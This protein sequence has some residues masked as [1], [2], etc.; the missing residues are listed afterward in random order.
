M[1]N[2]KKNNLEVIENCTKKSCDARYKSKDF[3]TQ[4]N[5]GNHLKILCCFDSFRPPFGRSLGTG[6]GGKSL[7]SLL[8]NLKQDMEIYVL[9]FNNSISA[10][11]IFKNG[12]HLRNVNYFVVP[13][14][15]QITEWFRDI[16][17]QR[18]FREMISDIKPDLIISQRYA[19]PSA[20][21]GGHKNGIPTIAFV[22]SYKY[23]YPYKEIIPDKEKEVIAVEGGEIKKY[24]R[25][26]RDICE[27]P[28]AKN[29][30]KRNREA[31]KK[32]NVVVVNSKFMAKIAEESYK[33]M[34]EV[35]YP[36]V[37]FSEFKADERNPKYITF[38]RPAFEKGIEIFLR[39]AQKLTDK[40]FLCVGEAS[41]AYEGKLRR[42]NNIN[43]TGWVGDMKSIYAETKI[44]IV[45]SLCQEAFGRV[46]VES[47]INKIPCIVSNR[48]GLPEVV[49]D[50]ALIVEN[51][52]DVQDWCNKI[53]YLCENLDVYT[54]LSERCF[55]RAKLFDPEKQYQ[56]FRQLIKQLTH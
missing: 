38:I 35:I 26:L 18:I 44:L 51:P 19:N 24:L 7:Y 31:I 48:G 16:K 33:I 41:K 8:S 47:M 12:L 32:T 2:S 9:C 40:K 46:V 17:Q 39:I 23:L 1:T 37:D 42:L 14:F 25:Y 36:F 49:G 20:V 28:I 30:V 52:Y 11:K 45:P 4:I 54:D 27:Y 3:K 55:K 6:G 13:K 34:P 5:M 53:S 43:Y 21:R 50:A 10:I 29:F 22:T 15:W 56:K